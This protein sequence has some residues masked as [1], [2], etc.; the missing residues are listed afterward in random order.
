MICPGGGFSYVGSLHEGFPHAAVLS[1]KGFNVFVLKYRAGSGLKAS[2]DLASAVSYIF[3]NA[4]AL[5]I[6]IE[7]Y[8]RGGVLPVHGWSAISR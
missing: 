5:E 3:R 4:D 6:G 2:E 1:K 8:S 7:G